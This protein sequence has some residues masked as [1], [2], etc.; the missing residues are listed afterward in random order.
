MW[1]IWNPDPSHD[2][3][4]HRRAVDKER[5]FAGH[6]GETTVLSVPS[7][8]G[9]EGLALGITPLRPGAP[10][11]SPGLAQVADLPCRSRKGSCA[12]LLPAGFYTIEQKMD[13]LT[14]APHARFVNSKG[15][16]A[17]EHLPLNRD[18]VRKQSPKEGWSIPLQF[19]ADAWIRQ[20]GDAYAQTI[21]VFHSG[22][23]YERAGWEW[24]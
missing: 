16:T 12:E 23:C 13:S 4:E 20:T 15:K 18:L 8:R 1:S 22:R 14:G 24:W 19:T 5:R 6:H 2:P 9:C 11:R 17:L 21:V 7:E 10:G 3:A